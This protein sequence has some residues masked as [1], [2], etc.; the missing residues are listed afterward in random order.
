MG[1]KQQ[2]WWYIIHNNY[3]GFN[4][5]KWWYIYIYIYIYSDW[6]FGTMDFYFPEYMGFN[7]QKWWFGSME[8]YDF[9]FSWG[10]HNPNWRTP[11]FF[12]GVAGS[13][14]N[15]S[16][17]VLHPQRNSRLIPWP[18]RYNLLSGTNPPWSIS[19]S[20]RFAICMYINESKCACTVYTI[21]IYI[22]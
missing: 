19:S 14:T 9:P 15:Q 8:F 6:W 5:Q 22:I 20:S 1:F 16:Y 2:K 4:Q 11:S 18:W 21:Y 12:R 13:T 7:Q 17:L 10:F 3:M